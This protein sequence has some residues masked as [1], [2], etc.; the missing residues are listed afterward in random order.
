[1]IQVDF[2]SITFTLVQMDVPPAQMSFLERC[3]TQGFFGTHSFGSHFKSQVVEQASQK[4]KAASQEMERS[5]G[6]E[7]DV[8]PGFQGPVTNELVL[9]WLAVAHIHPNSGSCVQKMK[10]A[11]HGYLGPQVEWA[12]AMEPEA[13]VLRQTWL[14]CPRTEESV[15]NVKKFSGHQR[16]SSVFLPPF[17]IIESPSTLSEHFRFFFS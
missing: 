3:H 8:Q 5:L 17:F 4:Y 14:T 2:S 13:D 6:R 1:M 16:M 12:G 15:T 11:K 9:P 10:G 7:S